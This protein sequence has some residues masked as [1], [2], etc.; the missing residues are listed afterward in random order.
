MEEEA[1]TFCI[2]FEGKKWRT[3]TKMIRVKVV[4]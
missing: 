2:I 1:N 3:A 4:A